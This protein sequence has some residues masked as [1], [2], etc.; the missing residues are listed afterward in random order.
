MRSLVH[1]AKAREL[2][3][4]TD[5]ADPVPAAAL[6]AEPRQESGHDGRLNE[7]MVRMKSKWCGGWQDERGICDEL[8]RG[9]NPTRPSV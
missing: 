4:V 5:L 8:R 3:Q 1:K 9:L 7:I 2:G 6:L